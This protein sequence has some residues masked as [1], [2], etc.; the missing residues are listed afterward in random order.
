MFPGWLVNILLC[1]SLRVANPK[2]AHLANLASV[3]RAP[4]VCGRYPYPE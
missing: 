3:H 1:E 2:L 4:S